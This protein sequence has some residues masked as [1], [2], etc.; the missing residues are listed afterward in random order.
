LIAGAGFTFER[1]VAGTSGE[2]IIA[3]PAAYQIS[4]LIAEQ[5]VVVLGAD[6]ILYRASEIDRQLTGVS[7]L[8][9][10]R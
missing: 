10:T 7:D 1:I 8:R 2:G 9:A 3:V 6:Q 4:K 5:T